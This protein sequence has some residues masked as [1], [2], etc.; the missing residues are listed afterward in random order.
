MGRYAHQCQGLV[1]GEEPRSERETG[2]HDCVKPMD[3]HITYK[4]LPQVVERNS[5][6]RSLTKD[7]PHPPT[8]RRPP[9][10]E[11]SPRKEP[12]GVARIGGITSRQEEEGEPFVYDAANRMLAS[13]RPIE[14]SEDPDMHRSNRQEE[15]PL[16]EQWVSEYIP[17]NVLPWKHVTSSSTD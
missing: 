9:S 14:H 4:P 8:N 13:C 5:S 15:K 10:R 16:K 6:L 2:P 11:R 12:G 3:T 1:E 7:R 17:C